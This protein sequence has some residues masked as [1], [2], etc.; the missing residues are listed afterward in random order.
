MT[1]VIEPRYVVKIGRVYD[2]YVPLPTACGE[3]IKPGCREIILYILEL[4]RMFPPIRIDEAD[5]VVVLIEYPDLFRRVRDF[6]GIDPGGATGEWD[7]LAVYPDTD[8][9]VR[10]LKGGPDSGQ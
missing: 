6:D 4:L 5:L 1:Q 2:K 3:S 10:H 9:F 7:A 8:A